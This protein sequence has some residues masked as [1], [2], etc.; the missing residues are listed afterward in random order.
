M[1]GMNGREVAERLRAIYPG[2]TVVFMSGYTDDA[3]IQ[4][5]VADAQTLLLRKP[6]GPGEL[7]RAVRAVLDAAAPD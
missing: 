4:H 3:I 1:P 6:F 2:L 7:E 5:G